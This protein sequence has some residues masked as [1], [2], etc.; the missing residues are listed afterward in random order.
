MGRSSQNRSPSLRYSSTPLQWQTFGPKLLVAKSGRVFSPCG[1]PCGWPFMQWHCDWTSGCASFKA[2]GRHQQLMSSKRS[3]VRARAWASLIDDKT[4][5]NGALALLACLGELLHSSGCWRLALHVHRCLILWQVL[6]SCIWQP[7]MEWIAAAGS[8]SCMAHDWCKAALRQFLHEDSDRDQV[9]SVKAFT[10]WPRVDELAHDAVS[11]VCNGVAISAHAPCREHPLLCK[12][13]TLRTRITHMCAEYAL[14][15]FD[16]E[17]Q[18]NCLWLS[19]QQGMGIPWR[20]IKSKTLT[21]LRVASVRAHQPWVKS[22][23]RTMSRNGQW[24]DTYALQA[25]C[26]AWGVAVYVHG[27]GGTW[28]LDPT[29]N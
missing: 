22:A 3:G 9:A 7:S 4:I 6:L 2:E 18:G 24:A 20:I 27:L 23:A 12:V 13:P 10:Q 25:L 16:N 26:D 8:S 21:K 17:G 1:G 14:Y 28:K 5:L 11:G 19:A 15:L 29:F